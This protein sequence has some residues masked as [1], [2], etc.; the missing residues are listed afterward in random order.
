M[1]ASSLGSSPVR[2]GTLH[3]FDIENQLGGWLTRARTAM[4]VQRYVESGV[5]GPTDVVIVA[6]AERGCRHWIFNVPAGW[7]RRIC[8][9][10]V[11]AADHQLIQEVS[12]GVLRRLDELVIASGDGGFA[13]LASRAAAAGVRVT[14]VVGDGR[15]AAVLRRRCHR[16]IQL[17]PAMSRSA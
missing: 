8:A 11:D 14:S 13:A 16:T 4:A 10:T 7:G 3:L 12:G 2:S 1:S 5:M 6:G 9:D 15:Q 17:T